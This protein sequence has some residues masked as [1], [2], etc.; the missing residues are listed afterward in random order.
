[1]TQAGS[2]TWDIYI[3]YHRCP[4]CG[5]IQESRSGFA[6]QDGSLVKT[7]VCNDCKTKFQ[8]IKRT[9]K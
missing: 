4:H 1:M 8:V 9:R 2:H 5:K 7:L 6:R 3:A